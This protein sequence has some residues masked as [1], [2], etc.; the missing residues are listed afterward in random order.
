MWW[1]QNLPRSW[2]GAVEWQVM[3]EV[4]RR[5][6]RIGARQDNVISR[7]QLLGAGVGRGAIAHRVAAGRWQRLHRNVYLLGPAA[8]SLMARARAAVLACGADVV[9]SHRSAAEMFG[10]LPEIGGEVHV[11]VA[12]RNVAPRE[13]VRL[14]RVAAFGPGE[15]TNM[16]G[17][18]VTSVARA[19]CDLAATEPQREVEH[20]YQ[21]ALY[22]RIVTPRAVARCT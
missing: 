10:L 13:G 22:R 6:A 19:I 18:P 14:H 1:L 15:V 7:E 16:R 5:I 3:H 9:V 8:P 4:E 20:A 12:G 17:I 11:T 2:C 21:E